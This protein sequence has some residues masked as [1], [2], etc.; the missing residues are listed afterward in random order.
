MILWNIIKI[1]K[2]KQAVHSAPLYILNDQ[3]K[4]ESNFK[5]EFINEFKRTLGD[6]FISNENIFAYIYAYLNNIN[7]I[8]NYNDL[9][10][11]N[12]P[13]VPY[14]CSKEEYEWMVSKG[15]KLIQL[16]LFDF[17]FESKLNVNNPLKINVKNDM[18]IYVN[19]DV[20][21]NTNNDI[22]EFK[23][24]ACKVLSNWIKARI[25]EELSIED[26]LYL[27]KMIFVIEETIKLKKEN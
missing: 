26:I 14:P 3:N 13:R 2:G 16:H 1:L 27:E 24:G 18:K 15:A 4:I 17:D 22:W 19:N 7:Y 8:D 11:Q 10:K 5:E 9:L 21:F 25:D 6:E 20:L 23:I 12:Y